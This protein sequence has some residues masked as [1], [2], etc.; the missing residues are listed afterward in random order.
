MLRRARAGFA[1]AGCGED[2]AAAAVVDRMVDGSGAAEA[3][4]DAD[5]PPLRAPRAGSPPGLR[6]P[7]LDAAPGG[8][9]GSVELVS[10]GA[11]DDAIAVS[12]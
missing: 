6:R 1:E 10:S 11:R 5:P 2:A 7:R 9:T 4:P 8:D 12:G 3:L